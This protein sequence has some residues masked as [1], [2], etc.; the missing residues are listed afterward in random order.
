MKF[1]I[2]SK[3]I[4]LLAIGNLAGLVSLLLLAYSPELHVLPL[5]PVDFVKFLFQHA[6][7]TGLFILETLAN[8]LIPL[9]PIFISGALLGLILR[10]YS[11]FTS[12]VVVLIAIFWH[13][14][15]LIFLPSSR[16]DEVFLLQYFTTVATVAA[17]TPLFGKLGSTVQLRLTRRSTGPRSRSRGSS[18][19]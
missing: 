18:V 1:S 16:V 8:I 7:A 9:S 14:Q 17:L 10:D 3:W 19:G 6:G 2:Q 13:T 5:F 4:K 15:P 12:F 11:F